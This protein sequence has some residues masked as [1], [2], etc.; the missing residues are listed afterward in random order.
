MRSSGR[1]IVKIDK[2]L[3]DEITLHNGTVLYLDGSF[4]Q[5]ENRIVQGVIHSVPPKFSHIFREGD[6]VFFHHSLVVGADNNRPVI[7]WK[8]RLFN[9][10]YTEEW[11]F[12][13]LVY[14]I[15]RN[16]EYIS[17]NDFVF[18]KPIEVEKYEKIGSLWIPDSAAPEEPNRATLVYSN[19]VVN[20][21]FDIKVGDS[22]YV[23]EKGRY[24]M[25]I[26]GEQLWRMRASRNLLAYA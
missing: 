17:V 16:G 14:L 21:E 19:D 3:K 5:F 26:D 10:D 13:C 25:D 15:K 23:S 9:L 1:L 4:N 20:E 8:E 24:V 22:Y 12:N 6:T 7:D 2:D 11:S 18:M